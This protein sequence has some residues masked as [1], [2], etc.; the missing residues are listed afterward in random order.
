[1][2]DHI[3]PIRG[4]AHADRSAVFLELLAQ[5]RR[6]QIDINCRTPEGLTPAPYVGSAPETGEPVIAFEREH[7]IRAYAIVEKVVPER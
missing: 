2:T 3:Y 4:I 7:Q 1:M 5:P 6:L